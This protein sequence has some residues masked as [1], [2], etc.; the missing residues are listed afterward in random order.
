MLLSVFQ[1][2]YSSTFTVLCAILLILLGVTPA[3]TVYQSSRSHAYQQ[4]SIIASVYVATLLIVLLLYSTR[5]YSNRAVLQAIPKPYVPVE[6]GEVGSLVR[7][8]IERALRRSAVVAWN[9]RPRDVRGELLDTSALGHVTT[10]PSTADRIAKRRGHSH[11]RDDA[12]VIAV[13]P[14]TPPWGAIAHAGWTSPASADMPNLFF[15]TVVA[16]LPNLIE[17]KAV[18]L[19][20][21]DPVLS[22]QGLVDHNTPV[23]PD[24]RV[25]T[26]LQR[27]AT[28]GLREYLSRLA[29]LGLLDTPAGT[30]DFLALYEQAR[31]STRHVARA[32]VPPPHGHFLRHSHQHDRAE[33]CDC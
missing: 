15:D 27:P 9:A 32:R 29:A 17:A 6:D 31:F 11:A 22:D 12:T 7:R 4:I 20:P 10:R 18:S 16:E 21:P 25:V 28:M 8:L 13:A 24:A 23:L 5:L 14:T 33:R 1:I 2:W 30:A 26:L 19:A 3:E